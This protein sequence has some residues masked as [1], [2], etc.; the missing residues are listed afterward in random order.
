[1][2]IPATKK[3]S[4]PRKR[5]ERKPDK[6]PVALQRA[7]IAA[8]LEEARLARSYN[9][10]ADLEEFLRLHSDN[11]PS[12]ASIGEYERGDTKPSVEYLCLF[13]QSL[14]INPMWVMWGIGEMELRE[15]NIPEL[16]VE[17]MK[18]I[19][20]SDLDEEELQLRLIVALDII[21]LHPPLV[22]ERLRDLPGFQA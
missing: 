13:C 10:R 7:E 5:P 1:M 4:K 8:R 22:A 19:F 9:R 16:L 2:S 11:S 17:I 3:A 18:S 12:N 6:P 14:R 15:L 20:S 21:R